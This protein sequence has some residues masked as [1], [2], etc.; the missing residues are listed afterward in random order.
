MLIYE[1]YVDFDGQ[2]ARLSPYDE[3]N[4]KESEPMKFV[5]NNWGADDKKIA[6]FVPTFFYIVAKE[7]IAD[8]LVENFAGIQKREVEIIEM[9]TDEKKKKRLKWYP[10]GVPNLAMLEV[11]KR[12]SILPISTVEVVE[13]E[14]NG[15]IRKRLKDV[16]GIAELENGAIIPREKG[17]GFFISRKEIGNCDFFHPEDSS[18]CL[19][20]EKVK[21][22]I[23]SKGYT[24]VY[25]LEAGNIM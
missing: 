4:Q 6:D 14:K 22:Y 19:C 15:K 12:V 9:V 13:E 18:F 8:L 10:V 11:T 25:F 23:E 1:L 7:E 16:T 5:W 17:K 20:T 2:Y 3:L 24:N 21:Q